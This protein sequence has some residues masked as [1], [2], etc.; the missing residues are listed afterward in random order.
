MKTNNIIIKL[1]NILLSFI[2]V[3]LVIRLYLFSYEDWIY[4]LV[5][6]VTVI[7]SSI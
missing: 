5:P 7:L 1:I 2:A 3:I 6:L 4:I